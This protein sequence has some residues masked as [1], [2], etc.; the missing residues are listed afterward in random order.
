MSILP[1]RFRAH[2]D[3]PVAR[4]PLA[5][6]A[7]ASILLHGALLV[8]LSFHPLKFGV[9]GPSTRPEPPPVVVETLPD[10]AMRSEAD[11]AVPRADRLAESAPSHDRRPPPKDAFLGERSQSVKEETRSRR[12]GR[13]APGGPLGDA[14]EAPRERASENG[15]PELAMSDL[16]AVD[17]LQSSPAAASDD[18][19]GDVAPGEMTLLNTREYRYFSF[20]RRMKDALRSVWRKEVELRNAAL[21]ANGTLVAT[22]ELVTTLR[23]D[24]DANGQLRNVNVVHSSGIETFDEAALYAFQSVGRFPNPPS[25]MRSADGDV[26]LRWEFVIYGNQTSAFRIARESNGKTGRRVF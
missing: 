4:N 19:L 10:P 6:A 2:D 18:A 21:V 1:Q 23:V 17:D 12:V 16:L 14:S 8:W 15:A 11:A 9:L 25:G 13:F 7:V 3:R 26:Q 24:L 20:Y 22:G 5:I